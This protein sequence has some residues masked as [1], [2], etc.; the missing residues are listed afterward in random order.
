MDGNLPPPLAA[1]AAIAALAGRVAAVE[2]GGMEIDAGR[3]R[4]TARRAV[5]CLVEPVVDDLVLVAET[6]AGV[7]VLA[8]LDRPADGE[9]VLSVPG[10]AAAT[11]A[12]DRLALRCE[13][14]TVDAGKASLRSRAAHL[15]G[16]TLSAVAERLDVVAR[17]LRRTADHEFSHAKAATRTVE[18]PEAVTAGEMMLEARTAMAQRAGI[19]LID[20]R[21][22][23]RMNG[24]RIT[25]G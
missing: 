8:I 25:M 9:A 19:V 15:A 12:Q 24:E 22:D 14:L 16:R 17:T 6:D 10:A 7:F 13:E 1:T 2:G 11:L 3:R 4:V 21:E 5:T 18:G 23:V 20:A